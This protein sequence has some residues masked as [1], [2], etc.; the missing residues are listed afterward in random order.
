V[1]AWSRSF[2]GEARRRASQAEGF[3]DTNTY[4]VLAAEGFLP[5]YGLD[6]GAVTINHEA[7]RF[8]SDFQDWEL[9]R[10]TAVAIREYIPGNLIYANGHKF[11]PRRFHLE[12]EEPLRF[13]ADVAAEAIREAGASANRDGTSSLSAVGILGVAM[14]DVDAPHQSY[15]SDEEDY[16][17]QMPVAIF[18]CEQGLHLKRNVHMRLVNVG[19]ANR[20]RNQDLLG[21][22]VC[23]V[24]GHSRSPMSNETE[25]DEFNRHH[26]DR[27]GRPIEFVSFYA[28]VISDALILPDCKSK[29]VAYSVLEALRQGAAE[30]L[31][32]EISDLQVLV[33]GKQA[34][35]EVDGLLYDP[36][37]GG[38]GLLD[39]LLKRWPDVIKAASAIVSGCASACE[40]SCIDCL[41][42]FRNAFY[43]D[44]LDRHLA[45]Q[46]FT[47]WGDAVTITHQIPPQLPNDKSGQKPTNDP[48]ARLVAMLK[49][50]GLEGFETDR[51]IKLSGGIVTRPDVY[52]N[53][54]SDHFD[55]VCIYLDGMSSHIHGNQETAAKDR[56]IR[57]E[58]RSKD[59]EVVEIMYQQ[60][61]DK[62]IMRNH[63]RRIAKAVLGRV[64]AKEIEG[65]DSW[66]T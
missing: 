64:N 57:E 37:P 30:V 19:A 54:L 1:N 28:D 60:L 56:I 33:F 6:T 5:G 22:P 65:G 23:L 13:L 35:D 66:F 36:M 63:I 29:A 14:C 43:H 42:H 58:L 21:Y 48:E 12:P 16:R 32:M 8:G 34:S 40:A 45:Y 50:A 47:E 11:V 52:F 61:F 4:G 31:D 44:S 38:S 41:Q 59:F 15:I 27:C 39:Q 17:F 2:K 9:R 46:C 49:A 51:P 3:D 26:T 20:V 10:N 18:G 7:P 53:A 24:C 55:G 25:I 62:V